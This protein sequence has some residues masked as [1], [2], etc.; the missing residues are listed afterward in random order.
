MDLWGRIL[1]KVQADDGSDISLVELVICALGAV[2][3]LIWQIRS[4]GLSGLAK[5]PVRRNRL[6]LFFPVLQLI[7]WLVF[8]G[9]A[10]TLIHK[11]IPKEQ[12]SARQYAS[13]LSLIGVE[14]FLI[15]LCL[16]VAWLAF[17]RRLKG[18]G[19]NLRTIPKDLFWAGVNLLAIYPVILTALWATIRAGKML[20]G[21]DFSIQ[22]HQSLDE[23]A[24]CSDAGLLTVIIFF[25]VVVVPF[26]EELLFRGM[27]QSALTGYLERPWI[28]IVIV[29]GLFASMHPP[30]HMAALFVLSVCLGYAYERSGSLLRSVF[31]HMFF[32]AVSVTALLCGS[33]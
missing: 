22:P 21:P 20:F 14:V 3:L 13:Y 12:L 1:S 28:S 27:L 15:A 9:L 16:S 17:A 25:A 10:Q 19:L 30:G 33:G 6:G 32:N 24:D 31:I 29:S 7:F 11:A 18:L 26:F 8:V 5:S 23:L 4:P 2:L